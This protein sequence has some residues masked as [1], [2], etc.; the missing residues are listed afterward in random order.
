[1]ESAASYSCALVAVS[2]V[3]AIETTSIP[4]GFTLR[5]LGFVGRFAGNCPR[6]ALI[7]ACTSRAAES[8]LR[9]RSNCIVILDPP[10]LLNDVISVI[11]AI[12]PKLLSSGAVTAD[13]IVSGAAPGRL[14]NT[15]IVGYSTCG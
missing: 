11:P 8:T 2:D 4:A 5:Q 1:M 15:L 13:A 12:R 9:S 14:A 6:A 7:A 10:V 3:N